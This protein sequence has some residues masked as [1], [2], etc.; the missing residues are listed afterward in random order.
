MKQHDPNPHRSGT[1]TAD[2]KK[3]A[4]LVGMEPATEQ[5]N[6]KRGLTSAEPTVAPKPAPAPRP[7]YAPTQMKLRRRLATLAT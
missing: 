4:S 2:R 1:P 3:P 5:A 7:R 6:Q